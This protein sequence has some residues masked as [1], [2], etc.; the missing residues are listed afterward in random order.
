MLGGCG[1][2][3][4]LAPRGFELVLRRLKP[5]CVGLKRVVSLRSSVLPGRCYRRLVGLYSSIRPVPFRRIR[6][7]VST[8][9][10]C[11]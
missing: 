10:N 1:L 11:S 6:T 8:S 5:A 7:I 4:K 9:F 3:R 2:A